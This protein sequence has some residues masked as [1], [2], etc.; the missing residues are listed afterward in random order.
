MCY[1]LENFCLKSKKFSP[2][3]SP[4]AKI[5]AMLAVWRSSLL[6]LSQR[7]PP[8][9]SL[10][11]LCL[12]IIFLSQISGLSFHIFDSFCLKFH[13]GYIKVVIFGKLSQLEHKDWWYFVTAWSHGLLTYFSKYGPVSA[14]WGKWLFRFWVEHCFT[15][16]GIFGDKSSSPSS[17]S[18]N[19]NFASIWVIEEPI[20]RKAPDLIA[21]HFTSLCILTYKIVNLSLNR[22]IQSTRLLISNQSFDFFP[23]L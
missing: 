6:Q 10:P 23:R 20:K 16:V 1:L 2:R 9:T 18:N 7:H 5:V 14:G 13:L 4:A 15:F 22:V 12:S 21:H 17:D 19:F 8:Q 3:I 11:G